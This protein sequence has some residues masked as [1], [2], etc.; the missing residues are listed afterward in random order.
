MSDKLIQQVW[1]NFPEGGASLNVLL[2]IAEVANEEG[3]CHLPIAQLAAGSRLSTSTTFVAVKALRRDRWIVTHRM[4]G[5]GG[6]LIYQFNISKLARSS[7]QDR[8][9]N[10]TRAQ[11]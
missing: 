4:M 7:R 9:E 6:K 3:N 2:A 1:K 11:R 5:R 8:K 10:F